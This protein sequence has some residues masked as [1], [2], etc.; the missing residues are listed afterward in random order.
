[1]TR[2]APV[3]TDFLRDYLPRQRGFSSHSCET[4]A[5]GFKLLFLFAERCTSTKPSML[6]IEQLDAAMI[7]KFLDYIENERGNGAVSRNLR[8][9]SIKSFMR[10]VEYQHPVLLE[11]VA[12]IRAIP[13]KRYEQKL[14]QHLTMEEVRAILNA[15]DVTTRSGIRDRAMIHLCFAGGL[16]VSEL[17]GAT[18][19]NL[20]LGRAPSLLVSG[21]GRKHRNLPL[22][23]DTATDLR[24]WLAVRGNAFAPEIFVNA[25]G[26]VMTRAGFEYILDKH[27]RKAAQTCASLRGRSASPHQLRHSCAVIMLEATRDIRKVAL[28]LG[29]VD[30]RTTE[31]YLRV[32]VAQKL[33]AV[34]AVIPPELRRGRFK[35]PD[36]LISLLTEESHPH[37]S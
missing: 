29:H 13:M 5:H 9:A 22:W 27:V 35:A 10:F 36:A 17:V 25:E 28:W 16:R 12:Q 7:L 15:P 24:A 30:I 20:V 2:L 31:A 26:R 8:L 34:E 23:R 21:K 4:Y 33:E 14:I 6:Q 37:P 18:L 3:I 32:D 1:M 19:T 11:Q